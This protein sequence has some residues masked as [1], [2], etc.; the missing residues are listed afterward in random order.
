[1]DGGIPILLKTKVDTRATITCTTSTKT[2][3]AMTTTG[4]MKKGTMAVNSVTAI[5]YTGMTGE[6]ITIGIAI[7]EA[8]Y[9]CLS[10]LASGYGIN[11]LSQS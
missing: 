8:V 5:L 11:G 1:M 10:I 3:M 2:V 4:V 7:T 9:Y 6:C